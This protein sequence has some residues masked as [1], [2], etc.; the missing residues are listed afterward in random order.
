[1]HHVL[2]PTA[3]LR[4][5]LTAF[6][7]LAKPTGTLQVRTLKE[8]EPH[9][10]TFFNDDCLVFSYAG[11]RLHVPVDEIDPPDLPRTTPSMRDVVLAL[12]DGA[13]REEIQL[14]LPDP[15]PDEGAFTFTDAVHA[16][17]MPDFHERMKDVFHAVAVKDVRYYLCGVLFHVARNGT[18]R[19]V[20]SEGHTLVYRDVDWPIPDGEQD[21]Y[22]HRQGGVSSKGFIVPRGA[23]AAV[24]STAKDVALS[25]SPEIT[26]GGGYTHREM[27]L[28]YRTK[29]RGTG[30]TGASAVDWMIECRTIDGKFPDYEGVE[31]MQPHDAPPIPLTPNL[32]STLLS[33]APK[34]AGPLV[35]LRASDTILTHVELRLERRDASTGER[36]LDHRYTIND[37]LEPDRDATFQAPL[38]ARLFKDLPDDGSFV[39]RFKD[40]SGGDPMFV[41]NADRSH[42]CVLMP[43]R[44]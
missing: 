42:V 41:H 26:T 19:I 6:R 4:K 3:R 28:T 36:I 32:M 7:A 22:V 8:I 38:F 27:I 31:K 33:A 29:E 12:K 34:G 39:M 13:G 10:R 5:A 1:M 2:I 40:G 30:I 24:P 37:V 20:A 16:I 44:N 9:A 17:P 25:V 14:C 43:W 18:P 15:S 23:I 11:D 35:V 21:P